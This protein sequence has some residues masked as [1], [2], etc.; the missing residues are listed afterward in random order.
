MSPGLEFQEQLVG[1][2]WAKTRFSLPIKPTFEALALTSPEQA[3]A[4]TGVG[5]TVRMDNVFFFV[6]LWS[7]LYLFVCLSIC[8]SFYLSV[9]LGLL[10]FKH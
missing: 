7:T 8:L 5:E 4:K 1:W 3:T 6:C 9:S 2:G 10:M